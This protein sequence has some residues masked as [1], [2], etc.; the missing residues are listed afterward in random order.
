M[1]WAAQ[2]AATRATTAVAIP[3]RRHRLV[4]AASRTGS[5]QCGQVFNRRLLGQGEVT[6]TPTGNGIPPPGQPNDNG[7]N[8]P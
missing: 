6:V 2:I 5:A 4:L 1:A 8:W 3:A 7:N